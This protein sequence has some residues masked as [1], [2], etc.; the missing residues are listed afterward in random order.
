MATENQ[1]NAD[2]EKS[3]TATNASAAQVEEILARLAN[4]EAEITRLKAR[5]GLD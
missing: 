1:M 3:T 2:A 4:A 5:I